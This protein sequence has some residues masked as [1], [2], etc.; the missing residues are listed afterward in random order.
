MTAT[1]LCERF[2]K[3]DT[4]AYMIE[5]LGTKGRLFWRVNGAWALDHP[6]FLPSDGGEA[7]A[8]SKAAESAGQVG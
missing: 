1:L 2:P 4:A 5:V 8:P 3:V 7:V 6:H